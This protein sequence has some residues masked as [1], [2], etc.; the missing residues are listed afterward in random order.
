[1]WRKIGSRRRASV[2]APLKITYPRWWELA[3][4]AEGSDSKVHIEINENQLRL[5]WAEGKEEN[6]ACFFLPC[7]YIYL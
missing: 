3:G 5:S 7:F 4:N 6:S 2:P 1:M